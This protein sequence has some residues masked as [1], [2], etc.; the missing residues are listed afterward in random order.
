M[1][2]ELSRFVRLSIL[3]TGVGACLLL[4]SAAGA[5]A[6]P[7]GTIKPGP[8][9]PRPSVKPK[10]PTL[11]GGPTEA[12]KVVAIG[13]CSKWYAPP[14][15]ARRPT[16]GMCT[17][18]PEVGLGKVKKSG[19]SKSWL[20][21]HNKSFNCG[22][23]MSYDGPDGQPAVGFLC[24]IAGMPDTVVTPAAGIEM[25]SLSSATLGD[26]MCGCYQGHRTGDHPGTR[27]TWYAKGWWSYRF[28]GPDDM[29]KGPLPEFTL[30]E[31]SWTE[32]GTNLVW[33]HKPGFV[34][35][36]DTSFK[37]FQAKCTSLAQHGLD[38]HGTQAIRKEGKMKSCGHVGEPSCDAWIG[39]KGATLS[40]GLSGATG[41]D[42]TGRTGTCEWID[43]PPGV[44]ARSIEMRSSP[45]SSNT[46]HADDLA[47]YACGSYR[48]PNASG[49]H[50]PFRYTGYHSVGF[51]GSAARETWT[52][53]G[54]VWI[55]AKP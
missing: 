6:S 8:L 42:W 41:D 9:A 52:P 46:V 45:G 23:T 40:C 27:E 43:P 55:Y 35:W 20:S 28:G 14:A 3:G 49:N 21:T 19:S 15:N 4:A 38:E 53:S 2:V 10:N 34:M 51:T 39:T 30:A 17:A 5:T 11:P 1:T 33:R 54:N 31:P 36:F 32:P 48:L 44:Q 50:D 26:Y 13:A 29:R 25:D 12:A 22:S 16:K 37:R 7:P 47:R 18:P 24:Q